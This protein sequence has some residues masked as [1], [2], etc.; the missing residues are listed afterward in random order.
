[1]RTAAAIVRPGGGVAL[2]ARPPALPD[3]LE[4]TRGRFGGLIITP[5]LPRPNMQAIR[6]IISG[7]R[8]RRKPLAIAPP[9][10]LHESQGH[11]FTPR[12]DTINN[13]L[14]SLWDG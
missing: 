9:L 6:I 11:K 4:A 5:I 8:G 10:I 3:I 13:G 7:K 2:I 14:I 1:L 12:A